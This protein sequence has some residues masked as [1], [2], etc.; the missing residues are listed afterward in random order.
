MIDVIIAAGVG[1]GTGALA[2]WPVF[3]SHEE[4]RFTRMSLLVEDNAK[5]LK[6]RAKLRKMLD[7]QMLTGDR[8]ADVIGQLQAK[9][10]AIADATRAGQ[11]GTARMI[12]RM[13]GRGA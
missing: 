13:T 8:R 6:E 9:L 10:N 1:V 5:L 11:N 3:R 4:S 12:F 7:G 2:V